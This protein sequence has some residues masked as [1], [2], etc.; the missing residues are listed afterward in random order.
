[1]MTT[2]MTTTAMM[3]TAMMTTMAMPTAATTMTLTTTLM[4]TK[5]YALMTTTTCSVCLLVVAR[6]KREKPSARENP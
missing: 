3:T 2:A 4:I 1:M 6:P 5:W